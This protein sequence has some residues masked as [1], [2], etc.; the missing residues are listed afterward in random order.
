MIEAPSTGS[1]DRLG[2]TEP[3]TDDAFGK[4]RKQGI[5]KAGMP[6]FA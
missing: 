5:E 2:Q 4:S 3:A 1:G 6:A